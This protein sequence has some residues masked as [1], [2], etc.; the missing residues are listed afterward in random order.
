LYVSYAPGAA[1]T[2][3]A[4]AALGM[5]AGDVT[6]GRLLPPAV[7]RRSATPLLTLL[8]APYLVFALHPPV[9][10]AACL[11]TLASAG[12]GASLVQQERLMRLTPP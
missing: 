11:V 10:V 7:R 1:G 9:P 6:V 2:L 12:F 4:C 8:A 3:F 5:L